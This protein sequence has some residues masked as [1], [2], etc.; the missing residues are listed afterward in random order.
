MNI[1]EI[2]KRAKKAKEEGKLVLG[3][4]YDNVARQKRMLN[5]LKAS[6]TKVILRDTTYDWE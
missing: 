2:I 6:Y 4:A 1:E 5:C 3:H